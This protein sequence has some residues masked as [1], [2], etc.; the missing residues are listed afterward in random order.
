VPYVSN[1]TGVYGAYLKH[2]DKRTFNPLR[3]VKPNIINTGNAIFYNQNCDT[4]LPTISAD[5][6]YAD[7]PYNSRQYLPNYHILETIAKYDYPK[8]HGITGMRE[9]ENQKSEFCSKR[10]VVS[11]FKKMIQAANVRYIVI[12][13][14]SEGLLSKEQLSSICLEFAVKNSFQLKEIPYRRYNNFSTNAGNVNEQL[15]FFE[16]I[17]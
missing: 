2:W 6:L 8:I 14:N 12:S 4:L 7:P 11:A 3:L 16:K 1:I 13:Y 5:L 10:D 15:Y 17:Q 9:Y